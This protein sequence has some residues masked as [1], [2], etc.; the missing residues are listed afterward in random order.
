MNECVASV[1]AGPLYSLPSSLGKQ[2]NSK[3]TSSASH[4]FGLRQ[5]IA[6]KTASWPGPGTYPYISS[7]G[8]QKQSKHENS[9]GLKFGSSNRWSDSKSGAD[10][11]MG[12]L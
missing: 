11:R 9:F 7:L 2:R 10:M 4:V 12:E 6:N 1:L 3:M 5:E 8:R